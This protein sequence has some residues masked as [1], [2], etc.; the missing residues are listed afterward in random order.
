MLYL[1]SVFVFFSDWM[2]KLCSFWM[3]KAQFLWV[4]LNTE[5]VFCTGMNEI[6]KNW[7]MS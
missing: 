6:Y 2:S 1:I 3:L 7:E 4:E 5:Y